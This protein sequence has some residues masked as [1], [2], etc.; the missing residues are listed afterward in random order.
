M[1]QDAD[2]DEWVELRR[3]DDPLR[4][5]MVKN[6]LRAHGVH[7]GMRG[8]P[9]VTA[10]LNRFATIVDIRLDVRQSEL[11]SARE[12]LAAMEAEG[13]DQPFRGGH[14]VETEEVAE[15]KEPAPRKTAFAIF[16]AM[17]FPIGAGHFYAGHTAAGTLLG[18]GIVAG[19]LGGF[20]GDRP[21]LFHAAAILLVIDIALSHW[22]VKRHNASRIPPEN[23]QRRWAAVAVAVAF[24]IALLRR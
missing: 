19:G 2:E 20:L 21:E 22:A 9:G 12:A 24:A 6:F 18:A 11:V 15:D 8:D 4:A 14:R 23:V 3:F 13:V 7:V 17:L 10:V 16:L 5:D 1:G